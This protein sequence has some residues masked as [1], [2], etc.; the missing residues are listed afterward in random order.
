MDGF[1][2]KVIMEPF[3][4]FCEGI[5]QYLP[6]VLSFILILISG[7]VLGTLLKIISLR[8]FR[9]IQLDR[10]SERAGMLEMLKKGGIKEPLSVLISKIIG[11]LTLFAVII[12]AMSAL[13]VP[14]VERLLGN[15]F[16]Y[17]PNIFIAVIILFFGYLLSNFLGRA[18][19]ITSV[20]AGIPV[21]GII[22]KLVKVGVFLL[23]ITMALEQ[24][25]IGKDTIIIAFAIVFGGIVLALA[26]AFG[27]GGKDAAKEYLDKK[28]RGEEKD[29]EIKHL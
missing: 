26:I 23:A 27:L 5:L 16:L 15:F 20:N 9:L 25:G 2:D 17:L 19:L 21:S 29:D 14:E 22:G 18:A 10:F 3:E 24:L 11:W 1:L 4:R 7:I 13:Q 12:I 6:N 8:L 28:L